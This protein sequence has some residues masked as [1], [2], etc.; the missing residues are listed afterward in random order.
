M[1]RIIKLRNPSGNLVHFDYAVNLS[2]E[3]EAGKESNGS[4]QQEEEE[5]HDQ[6]VA[7]VQEGAGGIV[8]LQLRRKVVTTV[9]KEINCGE[10]AR[11]ETSPPPVVVLGTQVEIAQQDGRLR[12]GD[13]EDQEHEE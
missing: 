10:T 9:D 11:Q 2:Y 12:A 13:D 7:K 3:P 8:D 1:R 4:G 5:N 6:R